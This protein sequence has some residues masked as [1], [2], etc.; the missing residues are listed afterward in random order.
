MHYIGGVEGGRMG[1]CGKNSKYEMKLRV[2]EWMKNPKKPTRNHERSGAEKMHC[3]LRRS[4]NH[5]GG[6]W[7]VYGCNGVGMTTAPVQCIIKSGNVIFFC[8][9]YH[10][11]FLD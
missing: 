2:V 10:F 9:D 7:W 5:V 6:V 8:F 3:S 11:S 4:Q 1:G